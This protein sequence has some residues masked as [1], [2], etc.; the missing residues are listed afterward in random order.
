RIAQKDYLVH[1]PYQSYS[2]I[3]KL[4]REAA[5]DPK[6]TTIKIT[7]YRLAKNSQIV[8][9]LINAV[10][11]GKRVVAEVELQARFDEE[12][13]IR[14]SRLMQEEGIELVFGVRGLKVHSKLCIIERNEDGKTKRYGFISTGNF[15]ESTAKVYT[16]VTLLTANQKIL[17]EVEKVF[18]FLDINYKLHKYK[19]L[20]VSPH[21][22]RKKF[23]NLIDKEILNAIEGKEA[24][25]WLKMNS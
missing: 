15:N 18:E 14:Y 9:S 16:D 20:I 10:K 8:S 6:V 1:A 2:Y 7:L 19:H 5:L 4:L 25:I 11:N 17:K 3:I 21:Y 12:S 13:N 24:Y 22:T 23:Y